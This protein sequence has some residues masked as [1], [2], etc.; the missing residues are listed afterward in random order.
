MKILYALLS[1]SFFI[2]LDLSYAQRSYDTVLNSLLFDS[3]MP[4]MEQEIYKTSKKQALYSYNL[5]N[6][7]TP[8]FEP[9]LT[10]EDQRELLE[11]VPA[12][13]EYFSKVLIEHIASKM[14]SN[15]RRHMA[16]YALYKK[17]IDYY[18]QIATMGKK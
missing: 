5:A 18:K 3:S 1:I 14:A 15:G 2:C 16:L 13:S 9:I 17:K 6:A 10:E 11:M 12:G 7:S 8:G 4:K